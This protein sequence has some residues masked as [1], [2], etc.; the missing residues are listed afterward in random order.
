MQEHLRII[1]AIS[2]GVSLESSAV[3]GAG[4]AGASSSLL[5]ARDQDARVMLG[6]RDGL[7]L[8]HSESLPRE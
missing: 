8:L 3:A 2:D 1:A 5:N 4:S 6:P 7:L